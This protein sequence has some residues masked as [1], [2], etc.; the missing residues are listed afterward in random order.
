[1]HFN[2][3]NDHLPWVDLL[4]LK[5]NILYFICKTWD[6]RQW[7]AEEDLKCLVKTLFCIFNPFRHTTSVIQK[8]AHVISTYEKTIL[9]RFTKN[10]LDIDFGLF[11][12][13]RNRSNFRQQHMETSRK[14]NSISAS[15]L[16]SHRSSRRRKHARHPGWPW[17]NI[18]AAPNP[19]T[20]PSMPEIFYHSDTQQTCLNTWSEGAA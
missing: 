8:N 1:M 17:C 6:S 5:L 7:Y 10:E 9:Q 12:S 15:F 11:H 14:C 4:S 13:N 19:K 2:L 3:F 20:P 16:Q 18:A